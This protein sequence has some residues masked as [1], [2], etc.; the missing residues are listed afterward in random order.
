MAAVLC[1]VAPC[2]YHAE[3]ARAGTAGGANV[4]SGVGR[5]ATQVKFRP[6]VETTSLYYH[7]R[8]L[9]CLWL[10]AG[11]LLELVGV[12]EMCCHGL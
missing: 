6:Y 10:C 11:I 1:T 4:V 7:L 12:D 5:Q 9:F 3:P 8:H 2:C